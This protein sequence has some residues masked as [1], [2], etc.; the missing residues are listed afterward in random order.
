MPA[1]AM[2]AAASLAEPTDGRPPNTSLPGSGL[3]P[4]TAMGRTRLFR[5]SDPATAALDQRPAGQD[6]ALLAP[7]RLRG[8]LNP[9]SQVPR[10]PV[11]AQ[12]RL[13]HDHVS[14]TLQMLDQPLGSDLCHQFVRVV[15][16]SPAIEAEGEGQGLRKFVAGGRAEIGCVRHRTKLSTVGEHTKNADWDGPDLTAVRQETS[17]TL[18]A[19]IRPQNVG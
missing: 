3:R 15:H 6:D 17:Q 7:I 12:R 2:R 18:S 16:A 19:A 10:R 9:T 1:R 13:A 8:L 14:R 11:L 5:P 4:T